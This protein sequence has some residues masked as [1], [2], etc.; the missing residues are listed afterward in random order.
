MQ[1][2][3]VSGPLPLHDMQRLAREIEDAGF[4]GLWLFES[5]R[6]AY[7][8]C[9]AAALATEH[10]T[11]GTAIAVAFP[12]SPTHL[13]MVANDLQLLTH[14]RFQLGLGSQVKAPPW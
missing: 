10:I 3:A 4:G 9:A 6:T 7:L 12:R 2:D 8:S 13:A 14:G 1:L 11:I 5:G